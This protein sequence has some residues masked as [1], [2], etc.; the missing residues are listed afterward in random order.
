M[1][2]TRNDCTKGTDMKPILGYLIV[3]LGLAAVIAFGCSA[4]NETAAN[5]HYAQAEIARARGDAEARVIAAQAESRLH[6]AQAAAVTQSAAAQAN[7]TNLA[8]QSQATLT[9]S[10]AYLPY[11]LLGIVSVMA[12]AGLAA[13]V[14]VTNRQTPPA[15]AVETRTVIFVLGPGQTRRDLFKLLGSSELLPENRLLEGVS[16]E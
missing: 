7:A 10:T 16:R 4:W 1:F 3:F 9:T 6:A 12:I 15:R 13:V 8:A 5:R 14:V 2:L 11:V